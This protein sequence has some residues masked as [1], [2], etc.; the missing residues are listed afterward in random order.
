MYSATGAT[1]S[2][3]G[4]G[5]SYER[6]DPIRGRLQGLLLL[7][8]IG[9]AVIGTAAI[10]GIG[11]AAHLAGPFKALLIVA[12]VGLNSA[13]FIL[14]F[15]LTTKREVN[16]SDVAPGAVAAAVLW[17]LL[18]TFGALYVGK[19]VH[20]ASA[21]NGVFA[22]VLGLLAFLFLAS[23]AIVMC[24]EIN[25]VRVDKLHPRAL[26]APFTDNVELVEGDRRTFTGQAKAQRATSQEDIHV[27][28]EDRARGS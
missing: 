11:T 7:G 19:V 25:V 20:S 27:T 13:I 8:T 4:L 1:S 12:S 21:T 16:T 6:P 28:F 22:V 5:V 15:K 3:H 2:P 26:L 9:L 18:Q 23:A 24:A 17:Q 10:S 14:A